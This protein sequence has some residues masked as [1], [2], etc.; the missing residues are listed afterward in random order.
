[1]AYFLE[2]GEQQLICRGFD[3]KEERIEIL[4]VIHKITNKSHYNF[5][6]VLKIILSI[7]DD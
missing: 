4:D 5:D 3:D 7:I 6:Y 1:M 2:S